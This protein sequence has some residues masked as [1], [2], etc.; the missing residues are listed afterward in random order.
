MGSPQ[1]ES[2]SVFVKSET[3]ALRIAGGCDPP[4]ER[5]PT[6]RREESALADS[7]IGDPEL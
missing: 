6:G 7:L 1:K 5:R 2:G 4:I 3:P